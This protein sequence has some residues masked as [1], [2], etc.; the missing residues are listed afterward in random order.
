MKKIFCFMAIIAML[1]PALTSCSG[2]SGKDTMIFGNFPS[3]YAKYMQESEKLK[4]EAKNIKTD[5]DKAE[6]LKKTDKLKEEWKEKLA[7]AG[8]AIDGKA[9]DITNGSIKVV[10]PITLSYEGLKPNGLYPFYKLNGEAEAAENISVNSGKYVNSA[11]VYLVGYNGEGQEVLSTQVGTIPVNTENDPIVMA[12]T[13]VSFNYLS[14]TEKDI[15]KYANV[16]SM[17]L[18]IK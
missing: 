5:E 6:Y 15:E 16:S 12:N 17:K 11:K 14:F 13:P 10:K 7:T 3:V 2:E 8:K 1:L 4:E 18:E 9:L